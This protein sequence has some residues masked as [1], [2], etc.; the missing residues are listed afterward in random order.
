MHAA[1]QRA[2]SKV[3]AENAKL[4][5]LWHVWR[6][7][8]RD[9]LFAGPYGQEARTL[10]AFLQTMTFSSAAKLLEMVD[11]GPWREADRDAQFEVLRMIDDAIIALREK[12]GLPPFSDPMPGEADN[13]FLL[14]RGML[15]QSTNSPA[16]RRLPSL[17]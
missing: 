10:L 15:D 16:Q 3:Q 11:A 17:R 12:H 13:A 5:K 2:V 6:R 4:S 1:Q 14:V 8:Q 9:K 7:E